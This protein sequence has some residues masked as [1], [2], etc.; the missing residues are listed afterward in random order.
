MEAS[1]KRLFIR[2]KEDL[3]SEC[4]FSGNVDVEEMHFPMGL[5]KLT[6]GAPDRQ[7]VVKF[8]TFSLRNGS[9]N[10]IYFG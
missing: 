3:T 10:Q 5:Q 2:G 7:C 1:T 9:S 6:I 8:I 4:N